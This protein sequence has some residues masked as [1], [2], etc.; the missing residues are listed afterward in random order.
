MRNE[1][2]TAVE[3]RVSLRICGK[4][5]LGLLQYVYL[6]RDFD[7]VADLVDIV[8]LPLAHDLSFVDVVPLDLEVRQHVRHVLLKVVNLDENLLQVKLLLEKL[9]DVLDLP[10]LPSIG[11]GL[12][13]LA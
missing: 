4:S 7:L 2:V 6:R 11:S 9:R 1:W 10:D 5:L 3:I 12:L 8:L 13:H